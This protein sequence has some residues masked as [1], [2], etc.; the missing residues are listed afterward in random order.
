MRSPSSLDRRN[1]LQAGAMAA[2]GIA[3]AGPFANLFAHS[4][5]GYEPAH[6]RHG[7][8]GPLFPS[9]DKTTGLELLKLPRGFSY[10]STGWTGDLMS[11]G[12]LTPDRHDGMA[13][14]HG[15]REMM[16]I[17]NHERGASEPGSPLP[18]VGNAETPVYDP[19]EIPGVL[20]GL[21]GGTT[22]LGFR[23]TRLVSSQAALAGTLTNCAGGMTPWGSWLTCEE[24]TIRGSLIGAKDHG[25]VFEVPAPE[26]GAA[27]AVPIQEMGFMSH[28]ALA[29]DAHTGYVYL[30]EDN[31]PECGLY[32][33]RPNRPW[34]GIGS[35][36]QGG[37]LEMLKVA[38]EANA[39]LRA[40][41]FG[42]TFEVEW[43]PIEDPNADPESFEPPA[44]GFPPIGG[45]GKSGPYLQGESLGGAKFRRGEG[46]WYHRGVIYFVDTSGGAAQE[47]SVWA[48]VPNRHGWGHHR[49]RYDRLK[50]IFVSPENAEANNPDNI[51][52]SPR[53][54][55][56]LC[57]DGGTHLDP[58][59]GDVVGARLLGLNH[60]GNAFPFAENNM[61]LE[62]PI[63]GKPFIPPGDHRGREFAGATFS[64]RGSILYVNIQTPGV[65]FAI[66][67]PWRRGR[68]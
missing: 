40:A 54:G 23:G 21:G 17:R 28:E 67:G 9:R 10:R 35:L 5:K 49:N 42:D 50:A 58:D 13:V 32:R 51:T 38:G 15:H 26:L 31:G 36:E 57:E 56:L 63:E 46:C 7:S 43:V 12:T 1:F 64:P 62:E 66:T 41:E 60:D 30:S 14:V 45:A 20:S 24:V 52:V 2:G 34:G 19:F 37:K 4:Q 68:L 44:P 53:G 16:L 18:R 11:D 25:Y 8:Y 48:L 3:L 47:G 61:L 55:I 59:T 22:A 33:F 27:S 65:T 29:V 6:F 39:D